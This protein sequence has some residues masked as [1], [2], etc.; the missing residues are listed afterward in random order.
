M[1][2]KIRNKIILI[3]K[4]IIRAIFP[5]G[6]QGY[7]YKWK[8]SDGDKTLRLNYPLQKS[9]VV[10]DVGGFKGDWAEKINSLYDCKIYIFEP[11]PEFAQEIKERFKNN[12]DIFVFNLGLADKNETKEIS[13]SA[14]GSS[15]YIVNNLKTIKARFADILD[16]IRENHIIKIDLIKMNIEGDEYPLLARL[17]DSGWVKN[18]KDIQIQFH[19]FIPGAKTK[20]TKIQTELQKTHFLTYEYPFVWENWRLKN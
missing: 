16:I 18:I 2:Q 7:L 9:S 4:T 11:I 13:L 1:Y 10:F 3:Y 8:K 20:R 5:H 17:I 12:V 15:T 19:D 14:D 6:K